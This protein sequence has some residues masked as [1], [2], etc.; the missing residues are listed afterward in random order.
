MSNQSTPPG[1][2]AAPPGRYHNRL[3][4]A[5][6]ANTTFTPVT[7]PPTKKHQAPSPKA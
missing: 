2:D 4:G 3:P 6:I 7:A 1:W 5:K